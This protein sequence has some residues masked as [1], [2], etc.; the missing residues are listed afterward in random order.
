MSRLCSLRWWSNVALQL[1]PTSWRC[2]L[3]VLRAELDS[4]A[5]GLDLTAEF[6]AA[7]RS[8]SELDEDGNVVRRDIRVVS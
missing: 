8:W 7:G 4:A 5:P 2:C 1:P 3:V 6:T